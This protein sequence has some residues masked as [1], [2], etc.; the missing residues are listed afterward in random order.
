MSYGTLTFIGSMHFDAGGPQ[1]D[2]VNTI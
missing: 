1:S 2:D